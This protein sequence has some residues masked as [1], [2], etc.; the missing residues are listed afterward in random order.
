MTVTSAPP[1]DTQP[2]T[3]P[4]MRTALRLDRIASGR[5][6]GTAHTLLGTGRMFGGEVAA[7]AVMAA[8][9]GV[10]ADR[11]LH[12]LHG[13]FLLPGDPSAPLLHEV[14]PTRD[15]GSFTTR[16]VRTVQDAG[17][18]FTLMASFQ[19]AEDGLEHG[20]PAPEVP[21]P[22]DSATVNDV[23]PDLSPGMAAWLTSMSDVFSWEFRFPER[24]VSPRRPSHAA[25]HTW[26]RVRGDLPDDDPAAH[27]AA[28]T[29][30][31]DLFLLSAALQRHG[32]T[33]GT[34][35]LL[36]TSLDHA[37][38]FHDQPRVDEW[39]LYE[40]RSAWGGGARVLCRGR[41][42]S[43]DGRLVATVAQEGLVR[44]RDEA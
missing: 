22:E 30:G 15:G 2:G 42:W 1:L 13:Y 12:S 5:L 16:T 40:Q 9:D 11:A 10:P 8:H 25:R 24:L 33:L 43:T 32:V 31:S 28:L 21:G 39:L 38:W 34:P 20:P 4:D 27:A 14:D 41:F 19:R 35:G 3:P 29:H 7:Q 18:V 17:V 26:F 6:V 37:M 44:I 23:L 36:A